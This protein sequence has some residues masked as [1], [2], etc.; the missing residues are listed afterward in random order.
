MTAV[1]ALAVDPVF[2]QDVIAGLSAEPK[3]L[4]CK[5]FYDARGSDLFD[6]ICE[7]EEYYP[8]RADT[9]AT[10]DHIE[11]IAAEIGPRARLVELGSGS[12]IKTRILLD[13]L[14]A[15]VAYVPVEISPEPLR[16]STREL[17]AA[18]PKLTV[19]PLEA[20][21]TTSFRLPR[22]PSQPARTVVY[23]PGSTIG[24]FHPPD[25]V[26]FLRRLRDLVAPDG[27]ILIGVDLDKDPEVLERAYD[28]SAGITAA[29]NL[30]LLHRMVGELG[31]ELDLTR[32][33]HRAIYDQAKKRI[34]MHLVSDVDQVVVV[35]GRRFAMTAG[36]TIR[37]E[38]SYK[39]GLDDF[40][41]VAA[42]AG[43]AVDDVWTDREGLF[44]LQYLVPA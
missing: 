33:S 3:T 4:P 25:A 7:L 23:F 40:A 34:E 28:D 41:H 31:A 14:E 44:S 9:E 39:Y 6:Q 30:N 8:T 20:D 5:Y 27:A 36:E 19:Q 13:H 18:Y 2:L 15:L 12:S 16:R 1:H 10:A 35:G 37:S 24:N 21:Y 17:R 11:A 43:L 29:F 42:E 26:V 22:P 38:V 32:F